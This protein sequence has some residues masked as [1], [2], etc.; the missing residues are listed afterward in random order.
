MSV[1][2]FATHAEFVGGSRGIPRVP[3]GLKALNIV[4]YQKKKVLIYMAVTKY[5]LWTQL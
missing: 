5:H 2:Q 3:P 1:T 4:V